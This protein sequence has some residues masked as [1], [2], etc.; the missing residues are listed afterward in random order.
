[1]DDD[2]R[3]VS[4]TE[5]NERSLYDEFLSEQESFRNFAREFGTTYIDERRLRGL[6]RQMKN[7]LKQIFQGYQANPFIIHN[8]E[9]LG[10][11][12]FRIG[13]KP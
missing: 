4:R 10:R 7:E 9:L 12:I 1:M 8:K 2:S 5:E 6:D 11:G 3:S 13:W